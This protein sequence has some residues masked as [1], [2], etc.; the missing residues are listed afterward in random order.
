MIPAASHFSRISNSIA[1]S[2]EPAD[3]EWVTATLDRQGAA[4]VLRVRAIHPDGIVTV[5]KRVQ[6]VDE[7]SKL[8]P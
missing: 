7:R 3:G 2:A 8:K 4:N 5:S 6:V 1:A